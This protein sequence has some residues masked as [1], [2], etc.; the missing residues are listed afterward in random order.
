TTLPGGPTVAVNIP[1]G[2][3][4][5]A[6]DYNS[7]RAYSPNPLTINAGN[8]VHGFNKPT[9]LHTATSD[10]SGNSTAVIQP[11]PPANAFSTELMFPGGNSTIIGPF[12]TA[13]NQTKLYHCSLH[14]TTMAGTL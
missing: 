6:F 13:V 12:I 8:S 5:G 9:N 7:A 1:T 11:V 10:D 4:G 14:P 2:A 3:A